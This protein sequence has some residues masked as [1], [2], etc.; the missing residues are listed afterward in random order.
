MKIQL[1]KKK[2]DNEGSWYYARSANR[3]SVC[4]VMYI[5]KLMNYVTERIAL[6]VETGSP[7]DLSHCFICLEV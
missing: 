4:V 3:Y 5:T 1:D 6:D 7:D 2:L